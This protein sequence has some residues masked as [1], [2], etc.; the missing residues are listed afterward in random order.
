VLCQIKD[1]E[2]SIE[3]IAIDNNFSGSIL[4][5]IN[6]SII[7]NNAYGYSDKKMEIKNNPLTIFPIASIT[8]LFIKQSILLLAESQKLSL[9]DT[10]SKYFDFFNFSNR[11][12]ISDLLYHKSGI[13]DIHNRIP[14]FNQPNKLQDS[15]SSIELLGFINSFTQLEFEP[16]SQVSYSNS[17][18]LILA[19]IF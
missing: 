10:L 16:G 19:S 8:K 4:I 18:Y 1:L 12:T 6:D 7:L 3:K 9:N 15:V 14:C 11:V 17:N 2:K 5:A 13:P